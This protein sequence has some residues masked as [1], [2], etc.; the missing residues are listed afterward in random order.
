MTIEE[1]T[2]DL[3][4]M[5]LTVPYK[6]SQR[7]YTTFTPIVVRLRDRDGGEGFGEAHLTPGY[8]YETPIGAWDFC[9]SF[10]ADSIGNDST[11]LRAA[12]MARAADSPG[13]ASAMLAA[14]DMLERHP[15]LEISRPTRI[16]LLA[17]CQAKEPSSIR[18]EVDTLLE[19]GFRTLKV[20][21]GFDVDADLARVEYIQEACAGRATLRLDANRAFSRAQGCE[22]AAR[23]EPANIELFE[24][25]CASAD[26]DSNAAVAQVSTVPVMLDESIYT[27][28]DID[29]AATLKG[30]G[31]IKLKLKKIGSVEML[32]DALNRIRALGLEPVMGD[33]VSVEIAC[34]MEACVARTTITNAGEMNGFLKPVNRLFAN[35]LPFVNGAIEMPQ[36]YRPALDAAAYARQVTRSERFASPSIRISAGGTS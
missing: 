15:L 28:A 5:P 10:A 14:V 30:V 1:F 36:G 6:V 23:L 34:W 13:A 33:G 2:L 27:V 7:T 35:P 17:P 31:F 19:Q 21:V 4:N 26:W 18:D 3:L 24:Q 11:K 29:R 9:R 32:K 20:K 16:P 8:S 12:V 22:F 25:P